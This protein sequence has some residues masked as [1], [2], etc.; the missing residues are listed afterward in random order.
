MTEYVISD[1]HFFHRNII[2]YCKRPFKSVEEMNSEMIRKWHRRVK[3]D[4][5]VYH[6][7]DVGMCQCRS[8]EL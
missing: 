1:T 6:L 5:I 7:G 3:P 8:Y 4:D 2:D